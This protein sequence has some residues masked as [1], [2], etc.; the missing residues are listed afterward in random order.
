MKTTEQPMVHE[1]TISRMG[2]VG[3]QVGAGPFGSRPNAT[4]RLTPL[5]L[6]WMDP[7]CWRLP[8]GKALAEFALQAGFLAPLM[9]GMPKPKRAAGG[10]AKS[11]T[12]SVARGSETTESGGKG[13]G[14]LD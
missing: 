8:S 2:K 13:R 12:G 6:E 10:N 4:G 9:L 7:D 3:R 5:P 14:Q 1:E 11:Q